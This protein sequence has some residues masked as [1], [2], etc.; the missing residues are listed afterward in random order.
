[1]KSVLTI[2]LVVAFSNLFA[3][4]KKGNPT[5]TNNPIRIW[6]EDLPIDDKE[7]YFP[8]IPRKNEVPIDG[9]IDSTPLDYESATLRRMGEPIIYNSHLGGERIRFTWIRSFHPPIVITVVN[10]EEGIEIISKIANKTR[11]DNSYFGAQMDTSEIRFYL[12][13]RQGKETDTLKFNS[14]KLK[15]LFQP[16]TISFRVTTNRRPIPKWKWDE[17]RRAMDDEGFLKLESI[18]SFDGI[19]D[20]AYWIL[21]ASSK[22]DGY[23]FVFRHSPDKN[24]SP[25]FRRIC[26][27]IIEMSDLR[28]E[29]RY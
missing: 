13:F 3:Q 1:M 18:P 27:T 28:K 21:E 22:K 11:Y 16:D 6:Y 12:R 24:R 4:F 20:G 7:Y 14:I 25:E 17:L 5:L 2:L 29:E 23:K 26:D 9:K 10:N 19:L 8:R 15:G